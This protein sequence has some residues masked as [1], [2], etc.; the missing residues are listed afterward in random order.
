MDIIMIIILE[1]LLLLIGV[2]VRHPL[3][4]LEIGLEFGHIIKFLLKVY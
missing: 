2:Y 1:I 3:M 4:K